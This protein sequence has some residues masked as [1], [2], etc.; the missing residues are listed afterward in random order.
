LKDFLVDE[1]SWELG[2]GSC[3]GGLWFLMWMENW[4]LEWSCFLVGERMDEWHALRPFVFDDF[5][6]CD[7]GGG[8]QAQSF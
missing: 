8:G 7:Q 6:T 2:V 5:M 4:E 3:D 1:E